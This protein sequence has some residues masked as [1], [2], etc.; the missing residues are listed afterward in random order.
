MGEGALY[1]P[2]SIWEFSFR[3]RRK[4]PAEGKGRRPETGEGFHSVAQVQESRSLPSGTEEKK[5]SENESLSLQSHASLFLTYSTG[6][7]EYLILF[8]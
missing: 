3:C 8:L 4:K 6:G 5:E 2:C 7:K 1:L